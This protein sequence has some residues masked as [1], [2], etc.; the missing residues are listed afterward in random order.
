[1]RDQGRVVA[2]DRRLLHRFADEVEPGPLRDAR[3]DR[4]ERPQ[5]TLCHSDRGGQ[6]RANAT[7][8]LLEANGLRGSMGRSYGAG[9]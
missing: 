4:A 2:Q 6:F 7:Q 1:M 8:R 3:R 9:D 5:G